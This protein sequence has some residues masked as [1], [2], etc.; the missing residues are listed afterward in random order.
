MLDGEL[1]TVA[2]AQLFPGSRGGGARDQGLKIRVAT[3]AAL[4]EKFHAM[5]IVIIIIDVVVITILPHSLA[6]SSPISL[7]NSLLIDRLDIAVLLL[8]VIAKCA[9][10]VRRIVRPVNVPGGI[11]TLGVVVVIVL[12]V[13]TCSAVAVFPTVRG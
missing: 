5:L 8:F 12:I 2:P 11:T 10:I 1:K 13:A 7:H 4:S 9:T 3:R 6:L